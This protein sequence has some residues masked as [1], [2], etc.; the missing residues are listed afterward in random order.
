M[1]EQEEENIDTARFEA[2]KEVIRESI[3]VAERDLAHREHPSQGIAEAAKVAREIAAKDKALKERADRIKEAKHK[4]QKDKAA[5]VLRSK[6]ER[7][8]A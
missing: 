2:E 1:E 3:E 4:A 7:D 5:E 8:L 6:L